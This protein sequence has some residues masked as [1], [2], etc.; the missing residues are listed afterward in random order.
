MV[1]NM[2]YTMCNTYNKYYYDSLLYMSESILSENTR[3]DTIVYVIENGTK[4]KKQG[5]TAI[6]ECEISRQLSDVPGFI[7]MDECNNKDNYI[8]MPFIGTSTLR[9]H[10]NNKELFIQVVENIAQAFDKHN[11]VH[12]DLHSSNVLVSN[13]NTE[14]TIIDFDD[15]VFLKT[16]I[17]S[18]F[19]DDMQT[20]FRGWPKPVQNFI[21]NKRLDK[22]FKQNVEEF[23]EL[24]R[25]PLSGGRKKSKKRKLIRKKTIK[26]K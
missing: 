10:P 13:N 5:P 21:A 25:T 26:Y 2:Y 15:S 18:F 9:S 20:L 7:Q 4:I 6:K 17:V 23:I 24:L 22:N 8:V 11:F 19:W 1:S 14:T 3:K 12:R 16:K